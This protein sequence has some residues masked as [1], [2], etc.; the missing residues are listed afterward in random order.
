MRG[1]QLARW[2]LIAVMGIAAASA[3]IV[4]AAAQQDEGPILKPN[5]PTSKPSSA[6]LLV[7]CDLTCNWKLDGEA[8]GSIAD[9]GTKKAPVS[10]GQHL[11]DAV[12]EDGLDKVE[13]E[14][15]IKNTAQTIV[16]L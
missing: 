10:L 6:T 1:S 14:I 2:A 9:G 12:T 16:R 7:M 15:E 13:K 4:Q 8:R 11:V 3:A 5:K